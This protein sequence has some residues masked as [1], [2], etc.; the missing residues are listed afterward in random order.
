MDDFL[1]L[2]NFISP[3]SSFPSHHHAF[4]PTNF[5]KSASLRWRLSWRS[6]FLYLVR[7]GCIFFITRQAPLVRSQK[8]L[9]PSAIE[10]LFYAFQRYRAAIF[11]SPCNPAGT[12]CFSLTEYCSGDTWYNVL[13]I[14]SD[15]SFEI[16]SLFSWCLLLKP[17]ARQNSSL[18]N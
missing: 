4:L 17:L 6:A 8:A 18:G 14:A 1:F 9:P 10:R 11:S 16:N 13:I 5:F 2:W 3:M 7:I 12:V 15:S